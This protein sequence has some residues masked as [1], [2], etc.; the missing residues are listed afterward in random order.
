MLVTIEVNKCRECPYFSTRYEMGC[1]TAYCSHP[2]AHR[3]IDANS[4]YMH[5]GADRIPR[6]KISDLCPIKD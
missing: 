5:V 6:D 2:R 3:R 4:A 1:D